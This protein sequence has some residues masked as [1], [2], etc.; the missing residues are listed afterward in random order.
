[1][2]DFIQGSIFDL[3]SDVIVVPCN[4]YG[5]VTGFVSRQLLAHELPS[6]G[7]PISPGRV[8]FIEN[9]ENFPYAL[10]VGYAASVEEPAHKSEYGI[11]FQIAQEIKEYCMLHSFQIVNIPLLGTGA[12]GLEPRKSYE[13]MRT[14][15]QDI[16][17]VTLRVCVLSKKNYYQLHDYYTKSTGRPVSVELKNPRVFL[18]YTGVNPDNRKWVSNFATKLRRS[19]VNTRLDIW[20]LKPGQD[21]AQWMTNEVIMADKVL[22][23]CDKYYAEKSNTKT[24]GVGWET[25]IIQGDMLSNEHSS[26][27]I[28]IL[29]D[30]IDE[31]I[32]IYMKSRY[33]MNWTDEKQEDEKFRELLFCL[34][35]CEIEPE[36]G[37]IPEFIKEKL[38]RQRR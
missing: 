32:P 30:S 21:L 23:I 6:F 15:F 37:E 8:K 12:G 3:K 28:V 5:E 20:H 17:A 25:M 29:R 35:D 27:Y 13:A 19:G 26:K 24:G 16:S 7:E 38:I 11:I 34:F 1:M 9:I 10:S 36:L 22:L 18:S 31:S 14:V 33:S 2:I 4:N